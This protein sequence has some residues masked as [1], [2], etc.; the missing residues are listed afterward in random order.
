VVFKLHRGAIP[1]GD[2]TK[3]IWDILAAFFSDLFSS[4]S[5]E[6]GSGEN[7]ASSSSSYL[8]WDFTGFVGNDISNEGPY[9]LSCS[10][11]S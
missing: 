3:T 5:S 4:F 7:I 9:P 6:D 10:L 1:C 8:Y 11:G 2:S